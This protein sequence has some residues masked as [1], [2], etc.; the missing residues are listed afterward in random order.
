L[1]EQEA[2]P[3]PAADAAAEARERGAAL[4]NVLA[5]LGEET[6]ERGAIIDESGRL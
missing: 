1:A 2:G 3:A 5:L 4:A 6:V